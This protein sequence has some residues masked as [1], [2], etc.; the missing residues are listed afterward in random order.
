MA[1][2]GEG[3]SIVYSAEDGDKT[4]LEHLNSLFGDV[5]MVAVWGN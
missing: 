4:V 1:P 2:Q 5:A 3:K